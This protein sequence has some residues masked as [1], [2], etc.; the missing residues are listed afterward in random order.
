MDSPVNSEDWSNFKLGEDIEHKEQNENWS[1]AVQ[2]GRVHISNREFAL[3]HAKEACIGITNYYIVEELLNCV[4]NPRNK[5]KIIEINSYLLSIIVDYALPGQGKLVFASFDRR[6]L[7]LKDIVSAKSNKYNNNEFMNEAMFQ[8]YVRKR[9]LFTY[10]LMQGCYDTC[11]TVIED[12]KIIL[13][14]NKLARNGRSLN[15][16]HK[17]YYV[18]KVFNEN[19]TN[20]EI[21]SIC[22]DP[23]LKYVMNGNNA[24]VLCFGQTGTG[25]TY[26]FNALIQQLA[27]NLIGNSLEITFYEIYN[28]KCYDLLNKRNIIHIRSDENDNIQLCGAK[29]I[30]IIKLENSIE[31]MNILKEALLYRLSKVTERNPISSRSHAVCNITIKSLN[32]LKPNNSIKMTSIHSIGKFTL[33]DLA[34]SERNY[35]TLKMTANQHRESAD[36]NF[37]LMSLKDCFRTYHIHLTSSLKPRIPYRASLLTRVL[38]ECF[39]NLYNHK[40]MIIATISPSPIDLQHTIN[41][42]DHIT[43][44]NPFLYNKNSSVIV[45]IPKDNS[46][47]SSTPVEQWTSTQVQAWLTTT[48]NGKFSQ[49]ILPH[50]ITGSEL[51]LLNMNSLISL[52]ACELRDSR[53]EIEGTAWIVS[54]DDARRFQNLGRSLWASLRREQ[55][56]A[57][58][59]SLTLND[60]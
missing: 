17:H 51:L 26:T 18:N 27:N 28:K 5:S 1:S 23:L 16:T 29:I 46:A 41:T 32:L 7:S 30:K 58:F 48:D 54:I 50:K 34:G 22:I 21:S 38:K 42:L 36:I 55:Q 12:S 43:L 24:T 47:L 57:L 40:T 35:D 31:L 45:E 9:P 15:M 25:K 3:V 13:H 56:S 2:D 8:I 44:M 59:K 39:N 60:F 37:A 19:I 11:N 14:D 53:L 20:N 49:L 10:E 6:I 52:F 4:T 33:V